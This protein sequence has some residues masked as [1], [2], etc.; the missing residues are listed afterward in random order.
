MAAGTIQRGCT[1]SSA[2]MRSTYLTEYVPSALSNPTIRPAP[3]SRSFPRT[4]RCFTSTLSP[5]LKVRV[6]AIM[7]S[8]S[9][10][11]G[12]KKQ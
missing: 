2:A 5:T 4:C 6:S 12:W 8:S 1:P 11:R 7:A 10:S 3:P 9:T